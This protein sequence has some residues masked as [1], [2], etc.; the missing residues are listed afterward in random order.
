MF[1]TLAKA[2]I[3]ILLAMAARASAP[4]GTLHY[5][6]ETVAGTDN[7]GD[8][9]PATAAQ[10]NMPQG[11]A[12]DRFGNL[13]VADTEN[14]RVRKITPAG[15]ISTIAGDGH[16]G[17]RGDGGPGEYA[18]LNL[19][20]GVAVDSA[21]DVYIADFGNQRVRRVAPNG[22]ITTVAGTGEMGSNGDDGPAAAAQLM[23]P[24][25]VLVDA[26]GNLYISEFEGHRVRKVTPAGVISTVAGIGVAGLGGDGGPAVKAQLAYPAGLAMDGAGTLYIADSQNHRIRR[27]TPDGVIL[28]YLGGTDAVVFTTPVGLALDASGTLYVAE[29]AP[30]IRRFTP[31]GRL[32]LVAGSGNPGYD[33]DGRP[34][35][36][37]LLLAPADVALDGAGNLYIADGYRLRKVNTAGI[38]S[39]VA[40][41]AYTNSIGDNGPAVNAQ[42]NAPMGL[43]MDPA[44]NVLVAD[45]GTHR[46]RRISPGGL[47]AAVAGNGNRGFGADGRPAASAA[48]NSPRGVALDL[49][50]NLLIADTGN[51]RIRQVLATGVIRTLAGSGST[52]LGADGMAALTMPLHGPQAALV[53][54]GGNLFIADSWS[55][56]VLLVNPAGAVATSAGNGS[57]GYAGDGG[58]AP[59]AQL[60]EPTALALDAAGNLF[61]ADSLN[62]RIRKVTPAGLITTVAGT[63]RD[64]YAGDGGKATEALLNGPRG[65]TLDGDG[66]FYIADTSN[67]VIRK[68]TAAGTIHTIAGNGTAGYAGDGGPATAAQ[69]YAPYA[70][71]LDGSGNV[72]VSDSRNNRVRKLTPSNDPPPAEVSSGVQVVNAASLAAGPIAPGEVVSIFGAGIGPDA[73]EAGTADASGLL[74]TEVA[75]TQVLFDG[76]PAALFYVQAAQ[77]NAQVPYNVQGRGITQLEVLYRGQVRARAG[78]QVVAAAPAIFAVSGGAGQA[79]ALNQDGTF[80]SAASPAA[81]GSVVTLFATGEGQTD[82]A[83]TNGSKAR[84]PYPAPALPVTLSI[85]RFDAEILY[86]GAAPGL[87]GLMQVNFRVPAGFFPTGVLPVELTV[88]GVKSQPGVTL[89]VR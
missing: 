88:G 78:V 33:G 76:T 49:A 21:A 53:G 55:H 46:V 66:N 67:H 64:G 6:I 37:S 34:A 4:T 59:L 42:L 56:R 84:P 73:G 19:P 18:R 86:A 62:H 2:F 7:V 47:I 31:T 38:L 68:V 58:R 24:R 85:G 44:G 9:G 22:I 30:S 27:V 32:F 17:M 25:N 3:G 15:V 40:G 36:T 87:V 63:G 12:A 79:A 41:D 43:A 10:L 16:P 69:L 70:V 52:G 71:L 74:P 45:S 1:R 61:I 89:A 82:P 28:N 75:T 65:L 20:Y 54:P 48:L 35:S 60:R 39:T 83:G 11:I 13:Y 26:A 51:N 80:N 8:G 81:R 23:S 50:G 77:I 5:V 72:Y 57:G 29:R 14:H